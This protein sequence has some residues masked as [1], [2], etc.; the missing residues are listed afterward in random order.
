MRKVEKLIQLMKQSKFQYDFEIGSLAKESFSDSEQLSNE[1]F[2]WVLLAYALKYE[3]FDQINE[4]RFCLMQAQILIDKKHISLDMDITVFLKQ[5]LAFLKE[6][7]K[8]L[9]RQIVIIQICT[10][11]LLMVVFIFLLHYNVI[12]VLGITMVLTV[13]NL[14]MIYRRVWRTFSDNQLLQLQSYVQ[15]EELLNIIENNREGNE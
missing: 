5:K 13:A 14:L 6:A 2:V 7:K 3:F 10:V 1:E 8:A 4:Q 12:Y 15:D 11:A 9:L